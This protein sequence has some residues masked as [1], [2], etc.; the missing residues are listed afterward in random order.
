LGIYQFSQLAPTE[1]CALASKVALLK[2]DFPQFSRKFK[3]IKDITAALV[4]GIY[5]AEKA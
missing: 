5:F 3:A 4:S 2:I 1:Y